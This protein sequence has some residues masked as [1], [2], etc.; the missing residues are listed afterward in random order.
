L[1]LV[2]NFWLRSG[3][4]ASSGNF[5]SFL[6][7]TLEKPENKKVS[8]VRL[9]RGFYSNDIMSYL[10]EKLLNYIIAAKF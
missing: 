7:N 9:D 4:A 1:R 2:T 8:L 6:E 10:E 5:L 3:D